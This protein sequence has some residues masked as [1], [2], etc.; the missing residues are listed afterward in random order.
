[1]DGDPP[2]PIGFTNNPVIDPGTS[3][4]NESSPPGALRSQPLAAHRDELTPIALYI[5]GE[6]N[7]NA[8]GDSV[9]RM[10]D[11]NQFSAEECIT[12]FSRLPLWKQILNFGIQPEQCVNMEIS[13][14]TAALMIWAMKVRQNGDWDH[15]PTIASRFNPRVRG[16]QQHWHLYGHTLYYYEVWSNLH[17]GYV[18]TAAGFS[19][20]ILL[21][22]AGL[23]Q[24]GSDLAR[25]NLP[26]RS[27]DI[28]GLRAW[29]AREDRAAI[30]MGIQLY[31]RRPMFVT[32][33]D[34]LEVVLASNSIWKKPFS[35]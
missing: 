22:G 26:T 7:A 8:H 5:A 12:D 29:D 35:P 18:G 14:R 19:E 33:N 16:G 15:K 11:M 27:P 2:G 28:A 23:E 9:K 3:S 1:M 6:M 17:Y 20:S 13:F 25:M 31:R 24:I 32:A 30:M 4:R 34:V 21:D 10:A